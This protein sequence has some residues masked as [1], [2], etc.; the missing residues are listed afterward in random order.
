MPQVTAY[1]DDIL[2]SGRSKKEHLSVLDK[3]LSHLE[4]AGLHLQKKKC[5]FM[6]PEVVYLGHRIDVEGLHPLADKVEAIHSAPAPKNVS[7]LKSYLG[8]LSYYGKF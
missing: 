7:E 6:V 8:L 1:L 2:I 4:E 5:V 3:V